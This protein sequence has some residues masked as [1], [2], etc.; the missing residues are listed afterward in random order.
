MTSRNLDSREKFTIFHEKK[1]I[2]QTSNGTNAENNTL[3]FLKIY[4]SSPKT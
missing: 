1:S 2:L 4:F 3:F